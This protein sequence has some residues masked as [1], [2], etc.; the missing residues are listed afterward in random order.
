LRAVFI[1]A[2]LIRRA[3][4]GVDVLAQLDDG[5]IVAARQG[6]LLVTAFHPELT[7]DAR[8]HNYFLSLVREAEPAGRK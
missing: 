6:R 1:R 8:M 4:P 3:G 7:D 2:P 5:S